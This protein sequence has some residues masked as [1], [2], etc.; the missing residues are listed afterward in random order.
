MLSIKDIYPEVDA[1]ES[2]PCPLIIDG[3]A[4]QAF[5]SK[6]PYGGIKALKWSPEEGTYI[7]TRVYYGGEFTDIEGKERWT[8]TRDA[9]VLNEPAAFARAAT[10]RAMP[11]PSAAPMAFG[12]ISFAPPGG[13]ISFGPPGGLISFGPP[14]APALA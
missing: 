2:W 13:P 12:P 10:A 6:M 7:P 5:Q 3:T 1:K 8:T 9:C 4:L 14:G 11:P